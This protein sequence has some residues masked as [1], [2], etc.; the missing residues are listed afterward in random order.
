MVSISVILPAWNEEKIIRKNA[1]YILLYLSS[2]KHDFELIVI[3]DGSSDNTLAEIKKIKHKNLVVL[4]NEKNLGKGFTVRKGILNA[5]KKYILFL[6]TDLATPI[7]ELEKFIPYMKTYDIIIGSRA[8]KGADITKSQPFYRVFIGKCFNVFVQILT[9]RGIKDTQC[10]FKLFP[11]ELAKKL[12]LKQTIRRWTF[13]VEYLLIAQK[14]G[15]TIKEVPVTWICG[16]K[17]DVSLIKDS[18]R[19]FRDLFRI[20]FNLLFGRYTH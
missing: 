17:S 14:Y 6:D 20:R 5:K 9:I 19:M 15:H 2:K 10:G 4:D 1:Q 16:E 13:D 18:L 12:A 3:N 11:T 8:V 7:E